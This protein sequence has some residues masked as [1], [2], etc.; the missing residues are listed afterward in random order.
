MLNILQ[1]GPMVQLMYCADACVSTGYYSPHLYVTVDPA[2]IR[3]QQEV[4]FKELFFAYVSANVYTELSDEYD[5]NGVIFT[6]P[7][8]SV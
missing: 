8:Y 4:N 7:I 5:K 3:P 6:G 2:H 1:L